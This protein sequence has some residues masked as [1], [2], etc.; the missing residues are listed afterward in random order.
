MAILSILLF[1]SGLIFRRAELLLLALPYWIWTLLPVWSATPRFEVSVQRQI[2]PECV[3]ADQ[4]SQ[5]L[6]TISNI[7]DALDEV[8]F[9][10]TLPQGLRREG[11]AA[12]HGALAQGEMHSFEYTV[13]GQRGAYQFSG[14]RARTYDRFGLRYS[15]QVVPCGGSVFVLPAVEKL[16]K[17]QIRPERTRMYAGIIRSRESGA[18]GDF[19]GTRGYVPGDPPR[20]LNWKAGARWDMLVTNL[21]EQ[22]RVADVGI[23]L[24][25]RLIADI[26]AQDTSL[27]EHSVRAAASLSHYFLETGNRVGLLIYGAFLAWTAPGYGQQQRNKLAVAL[28]QARLGA[29]EVFKLFQYLPVR[30]FPPHSQLIIVS[31]LLPQDNFAIR[32][33]R[34]H[35]Y[36][37]M[38]LCPDPVAFERPFLPRDAYT[39]TAERLVRLERHILFDRLRRDGVAVV[40]WDV[41]TPLWT[42][43]QAELLLG[44]RT[45]QCVNPLAF[46]AMEV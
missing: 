13:R 4:A 44:S 26:Q 39:E 2:A 8:Y 33:L 20:Y 28:A 19:L 3:H 43:I 1:L 5:V 27:F 34:A 10:D 36:Q 21:F 16:K 14:L 40:E 18:G 23:I 37:V 38:V 15:E 9:A 42:A 7:G 17:F 30:L 45:R 25:A 46:K 6:V 35:G 12:Y 11:N 22:E 29:H 31:P 41:A 24:D 32:H